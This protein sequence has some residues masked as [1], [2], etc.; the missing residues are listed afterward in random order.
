MSTDADL[1]ARAIW[2]L[3]LAGHTV[4]AQPG[5][6][7]IVTTATGS[8]MASPASLDELRALADQCYEL[9]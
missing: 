3:E 7:Y 8:T 5:H 4:A 6:G 1:E 9:V 2:K